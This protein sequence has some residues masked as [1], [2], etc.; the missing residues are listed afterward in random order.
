VCKGIFCISPSF[1]YF[2][3]FH[4]RRLRF[5]L[6]LVR[7]AASLAGA[8]N[9]SPLTDEAIASE[10]V[11]LD[12]QM[13]VSG[14]LPIWINAVECHGVQ[15]SIS[16]ALFRYWQVQILVDGVAADAEFSGQGQFLLASSSPPLHLLNL[17]R[18]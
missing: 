1:F 7:S 6:G 4:E 14:H 16:M 12:I 10:Q 5:I 3:L 13:I 18:G 8:A 11:G 9:P 2:P 15:R 17:L